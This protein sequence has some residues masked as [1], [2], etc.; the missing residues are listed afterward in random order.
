MRLVEDRPG[1]GAG[2]AT[3][4]AAASDQP[5]MLHSQAPASGVDLK[6]PSVI[7]AHVMRMPSG[8]ATEPCPRY[9][10]GDAWPHRAGRPTEW[11]LP[12]SGVA[13]VEGPGN[14]GNVPANEIR[15]STEAVA[16]PERV[17]RNRPASRSIAT[18]DNYAG[19]VGSP[20]D[21]RVD[22]GTCEN[23]DPGSLGCYAQP[24]HELRAGARSAAHAC[25]SQNDRV[26][27][28]YRSPRTGGR[29]SAQPLTAGPIVEAKRFTWSGWGSP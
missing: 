6:P 11:R 24:I 14:L 8:C 21:N 26:G 3:T 5:A 28:S 9:P 10:G 16:K 15:I 20:A 27:K 17:I 1:Q 13:E 23:V 12:I 7:V 18:I 4:A 19:D 2:S 29:A 25:A 22:D